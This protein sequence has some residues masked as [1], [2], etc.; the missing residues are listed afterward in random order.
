MSSFCRFDR[1]P[2][3]RSAKCLAPCHLLR[4]ND[5]SIQETPG[6]IEGLQTVLFGLQKIAC[7]WMCSLRGHGNLQDHSLLWFVLELLWLWSCDSPWSI[8]T[9]DAWPKMRF[10]SPELQQKY[11]KLLRQVLGDEWFEVGKSGQNVADLPHWPNVLMISTTQFSI[12]QE[13]S[14]LSIKSFFSC[15]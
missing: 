15:I 5:K 11:S 10:F 7:R 6:R 4:F 8:Q 3:W 12:R 1:T 14:M 9:F 13:W 2:M